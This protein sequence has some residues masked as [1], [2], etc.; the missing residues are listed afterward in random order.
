MQTERRARPAQAHPKA[1]SPTLPM[2]G[3]GAPLRSITF[4]SRDDLHTTL[5]NPYPEGLAL[6]L[7]VSCH[8][9]IR[10]AKLTL[11]TV[12]SA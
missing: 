1:S 7:D 8:S 10:M 9:F 4:A 12:A 5:V 2:S 6:A 11:P 3:N